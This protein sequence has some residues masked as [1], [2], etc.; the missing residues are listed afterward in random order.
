[1]YKIITASV[2]ALGLVNSASAYHSVNG[3]AAMKLPALFLVLI[4]A[5]IFEAY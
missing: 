3:P 5:K 2:L 1:M 4:G